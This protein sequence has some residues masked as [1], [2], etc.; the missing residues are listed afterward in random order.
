MVKADYDLK[1]L[2]DGTDSVDVPGFVSLSD[3]TMHD[4]TTALS[5]RQKFVLPGFSLNRF[6]LYPGEN[7]IEEDAGLFFL[8]DSPVTLQTEL[9]HS[10][11]KGKV[12][13]SGMMEPDAY[14]FVADHISGARGAVSFCQHRRNH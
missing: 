13:G 6:W 2:S 11:R 4:A 5:Q 14:R 10:D 8:K 9:M 12:S 3:K 7:V 1:Q